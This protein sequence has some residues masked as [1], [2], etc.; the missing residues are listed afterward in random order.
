MSEANHPT[1]GSDAPQPLAQACG[2]SFSVDGFGWVRA[3]SADGGTLKEQSVEALLLLG[4]LCE[5]QAMNG[6]LESIQNWGA[7]QQRDR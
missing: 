2:R 7:G 1:Q 6:Y 4:I 5:L 3:R